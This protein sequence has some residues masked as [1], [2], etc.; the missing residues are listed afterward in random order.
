MNLPIW[1]CFIIAYLYIFLLKK[2]NCDDKQCKYI[3]DFIK[4]NTDIVL[5][6]LSTNNISYY[7]I[8]KFPVFK[9]V[10]FN[11][12]MVIGVLN[13]NVNVIF[14][15]FDF[16][17]FNISCLALIKDI[18]SDKRVP[19]HYITIKDSIFDLSSTSLTKSF[20]KDLVINGISFHNV[21]FTSN[22]PSK[23]FKNCTIKRLYFYGCYF[24]ESTIIN[25]EDFTENSAN[26]T[27]F[28]FNETPVFNDSYISIE[29]FRHTK[30]LLFKST[31]IKKISAIINTIE[32]SPFNI[33]YYKDKNNL[34]LNYSFK[35]MKDLNKYM[36]C[37]HSNNISIYLKF[38]YFNENILLEENLCNFQYLPHH[39]NVMLLLDTAS[40]DYPISIRCTCTFYW[41]F[42]QT[43][44]FKY[45]R[46]EEIRYN[47]HFRKCFRQFNF[48]EIQKKC[49]Y[50]KKFAECTRNRKKIFIDFKIQNNTQSFF[51]ES[52]NSLFI[53]L[54][55]AAH[56]VIT[57]F[58]VFSI[59]QINK[60]WYVKQNIPNE[61]DN[62][63][64]DS[65]MQS[66]THDYTYIEEDL[67]N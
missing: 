46:H 57:I 63:N 40:F 21:T 12:T 59:L 18:L 16:T 11:I 24:N 1:H 31:Q 25:E 55:M 42:Q 26:I 19:L 49:N 29:L 6:E 60:L 67:I 62:L 48:T 36:Q 53:L 52:I 30:S 56:S 9:H 22:L 15:S 54:L 10:N 33:V 37:N 38:L 8:T 13:E 4:N 32:T 14:R 23:I 61:Q 64:N 3:L 66:D 5:N 47:E 27:E 44:E 41:I 50:I 45:E 17:D 43:H 20:F 2:S 51:K 39:Q 28:Y 65:I 7:S 35:W 34:G 58:L